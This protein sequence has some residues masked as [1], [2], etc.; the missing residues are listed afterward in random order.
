MQ[1][2]FA[3]A[4][5]TTRLPCQ[6]SESLKNQSESPTMAVRAEPPS[7]TSDVLSGMSVTAELA[8]SQES[9]LAIDRAD[10]DSRVARLARRDVARCRRR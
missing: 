4:T 8:V 2:V 1:L 7:A 3:R 6:P 10:L 5:P 9:E